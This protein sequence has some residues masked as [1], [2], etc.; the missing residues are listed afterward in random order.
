MKRLIIKIHLILALT[1]VLFILPGC[2]DNKAVIDDP[3]AADPADPGDSPRP[4]DPGMVYLLSD[5]GQTL[6]YPGT[7]GDDSTH[8]GNSQ[9]FVDST[10]DNSIVIDINTKLMWEKKNNTNKFSWAGAGSHCD[11]LTTG[12][13]SDWRLPDIK[14]LLSIVNYGTSNNPAIDS[15]FLDT[16]ANYYWSS[17][18]YHPDQTEALA[19]DFGTSSPS[20]DGYGDYENRPI[21]YDFYV[22]CVRSDSESTLWDLYFIDNNDGT[23]SHP[24]TELMWQKEDDNS[25]YSWSAA[26]GFCHNSNM[27]NHTDWRV[28]NIIEL[29]TIVNYEASYPSTNDSIFPGADLSIYWSSTSNQNNELCPPVPVPCNPLAEDLTAW[30]INFGDGSIQY[31]QKSSPRYVRCV[32]SIL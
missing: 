4:P 31:G 18:V 29:T 16:E 14:E 19:I 26:I 7:I 6:G 28:P 5:T 2:G 32:R 3:D 11:S 22:R 20:A 25:Y 27:Y 15:I 12:G 23:I 30:A 10:T 17:T 9:N 21:S 1:L 13:Y 24:N 8:N